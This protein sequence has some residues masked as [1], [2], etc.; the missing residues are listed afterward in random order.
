MISAVSANSSVYNRVNAMQEARDIIAENKKAAATG[1]TNGPAV[2]APLS[3]GMA[4]GM[5]RAIVREQLLSGE[6]PAALEP[7]FVGPARAANQ[8][9]ALTVTRGSGLD[10]NRFYQDLMS[11]CHAGPKP[12]SALAA[13]ARFLEARRIAG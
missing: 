6:R 7:E 8:I 13:E 12:A 3:I 4:Q 2:D 1:E 5:A 10:M 11:G 9:A